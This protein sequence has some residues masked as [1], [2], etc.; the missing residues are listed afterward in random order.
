MTQEE[1]ILL[2]LEKFR[3]M[4][5][6]MARAYHQELDDL[7]QDAAVILLEHIRQVD[8]SK[9]PV[10]YL[11]TVVRRQL[12][13]QQ[14][15]KSLETVSINAPLNDEGFTLE[16]T[17]P[18]PQVVTDH[19]STDERIATVHHALSRL[20]LDEQLYVQ[21]VHALHA[22]VPNGREQRAPRT[23]RVTGESARRHLRADWSLAQTVYC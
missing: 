10:T 16:E 13:E 21:R 5:I 20:P 9:Y 15:G 11:R 17:L 6:N 14:Q 4:L 18:E 23:Q 7:M 2:C 3:P 12:W 19:T 8:M 22:F 1:L